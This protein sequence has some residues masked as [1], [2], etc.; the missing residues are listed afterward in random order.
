MGHIGTTLAGPAGAS[1]WYAEKVLEG[2][3]QEMATKR[4][5]TCEGGEA[6]AS[7]PAFIMGHLSLYPAT[8]LE[9]MGM[10][11]GPAKNPEGFDELFSPKAT[12]QDDPG[13][14]VYPPMEQITNHFFAGHKHLISRLPEVSDEVF[15][16]ETPIEGLKDMFPTVGQLAAF[17]ALSHT[18]MH[19]GQISTWRRC[20]GLGSV[21]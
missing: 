3:T 14:T 21:M 10:D 13:G 1:L 4:A 5:R 17:M 15:G 19:L 7:H 11:P 18:M 12:C 16:K 6:D 20:M 8:M 2:I 9:A